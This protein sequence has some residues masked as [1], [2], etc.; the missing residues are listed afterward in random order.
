MRV[1][2]LAALHSRQGRIHQ[3]HLLCVRRMQLR[4]LHKLTHLQVL[5]T[6]LVFVVAAAGM[7]MLGMMMDCLARLLHHVL[8]TCITT[9]IA[10]IMHG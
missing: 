9:H 4:T 7:M 10:A 2:M 8:Y 1:Q 3:M 5:H 6:T